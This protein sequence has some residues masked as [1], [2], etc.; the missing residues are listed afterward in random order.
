M[1]GLN[2]ATIVALLLWPAVALW[3]FK[4]RPIGTAI[5]WTILGGYLLLP[6]GANIKFAMIPQFDKNSIP[7]FAALFGCVVV[8]GKSLK[9]SRR[10]GVAEWL[11]GVL[12]ISSFITFELNDDPIALGNRPGLGL[13]DAGSAC[14]GQ[15][16]A[17]IPFFLGRQ[18]LGGRR[19]IEDILRVLIIA[20]LVYSVPAMF[21]I[22]FSPQLHAWIYGY[23]PHDDFEQQ[24]R[25]GGFRPV[26]FLGH[27]LLVAFFI[28]TSAVAAAAFWRTKT[29]VF[30]A[31]RL[32]AGVMTAYLSVLLVLCKTA[33]ALLYGAV[34]VF[35]VYFTRPKIQLSIAV[36]LT[37]LALLY[38]MLRLADL[39]PTGAAIDLANDTFGFDRA[40]SLG[41]RLTNENALLERAS[42]RFFFGWGS[43]GRGFV[44]DEYNRLV[45]APDGYW[46]IIMGEFGF[47]GFLAFFGLLSLSVFAA[48][49]AVKFAETAKDK[50]FL[51][52]LAL[53]IAVNIFDLLPNSS[54]R[55]WTWLL[56][57]ALLSRSESLRQQA[58]FPKNLKVGLAGSPK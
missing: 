11:M 15:L 45:Y 21:E 43:F 30:R 36:M 42:Q 49:R 4:T 23:F 58:R 44:Y 31:I 34:L 38:P 32:Q 25:E 48:A 33:G 29:Q 6:V 54:I 46:V 22:R 57:G 10:F 50:L 7:S 2:F 39:V 18:F 56:T 47:V 41:A 51:S 5:L 52:A 14:I 16:V 55:P 9:F 26:V 20:G 40:S 27:G 53:I 37:S 17:F 1:Q 19:D 35:L 12:L 8:C 13:Y 28:S 3:L 24:I